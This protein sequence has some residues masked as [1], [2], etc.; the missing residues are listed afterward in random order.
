[1]LFPNP[2]APGGDGVAPPGATLTPPVPGPPIG[3]APVATALDTWQAILAAHLAARPNAVALTG[4]TYPETTLGDVRRAA[5]QF[6]RELCQPRYDLANLTGTRAAW[7]DA[8]ARIQASA[9]TVP[10]EAPYPSN[11]QFW[12]GDSRALAQQ[13]AA[14]DVRRNRLTNVRPDG[15]SLAVGTGD[16]MTTY[17][18]LRA[19][20]F[21][22]R[23]V[24]VDD[25]GWRYP[26]STVGDVV[27]VVRIVE[28]EIATASRASRN[29]L[30]VELIAGHLPRWGEAAAAV[31]ATARVQPS[32]AP[33]HD[34]ETL[35]RAYRR[36]SIPLAVAHE[37]AAEEKRNPFVQRVAS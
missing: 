22:R 19:Y 13:L 36:V 37:A 7:R 27:Q 29:P 14:V 12:L 26:A 15:L 32:D 5:L 3:L 1:M 35:W 30:V 25:R 8:L 31:N 10:W 33:Y 28:G 6:S 34:S 2:A 20:F 21:A 4:E 9:A 11:P 18:D 23:L 17:L 16:P 24:R